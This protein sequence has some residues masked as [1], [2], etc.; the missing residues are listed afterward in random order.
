[1]TRLDI[2]I[3]NKCLFVF[4]RIKFLLYFPSQRPKEHYNQPLCTRKDTETQI[5]FPQKAFS[6][7]SLWTLAQHGYAE[8]VQGHIQPCTPLNLLGG[9]KPKPCPTRR[10]QMSQQV[11]PDWVGKS[12]KDTIHHFQFLRTVYSIYVTK[13]TEGHTMSREQR[14]EPRT[15]RHNKGGSFW[16]GSEGELSDI[17]QAYLNIKGDKDQLMELVLCAVHRE[18]QNMEP[19]SA[20]HSQQRSHPI[21]LPLAKNQSKRWM[22]EKDGPGRS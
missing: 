20:S 18:S 1:M 10:P 7:A 9:M 2:L 16:K 13:T 8:T 3:V 15:G 11:S 4:K 22:H 17:K 12:D 6:C 19:Q 14:A 5:P 21:I